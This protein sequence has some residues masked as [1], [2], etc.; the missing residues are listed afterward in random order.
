LRQILMIVVTIPATILHA[1]HMGGDTTRAVGNAS[2]GIFALLL[3][4][5][6]AYSTV[7]VSVPAPAPRPRWRSSRI[8]HHALCIMHR[9]PCT[10]HR[11][12]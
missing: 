5:L 10:V 6:G 3:A 8:A 4:L 2:Y 7:K 1:K 9:A 12:L 11:A